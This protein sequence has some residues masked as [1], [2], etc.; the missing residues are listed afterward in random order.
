M[1]QS[2]SLNLSYTEI[3]AFLK[4]GYLLCATHRVNKHTHLRLDTH[5][6]TAIELHDQH[7]RQQIRD[8]QKV[9]NAVTNWE[10]Y[11]IGTLDVREAIRLSA[12]GLQV[13]R[14]AYV[15][16]F[17][18][19]D[20]IGNGDAGYHDMTKLKPDD[21][22]ATDWFVPL[23]EANQKI[24]DIEITDAMIAVYENYKISLNT[25]TFNGN[26][27][28]PKVSQT[29]PVELSPVDSLGYAL[30]ADAPGCKPFTKYPNATV[31]SILADNRLHRANLKTMQI[32]LDII[33]RM[34]KHMGEKNI[35][36]DELSAHMNIKK[37]A[38]LDTIHCPNDLSIRQ[39][40][41]IADA[42]DFDLATIFK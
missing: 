18:W 42:I 20:R 6:N 29:M 32:S 35:T 11:E 40:V 21:L 15:N 33:D 16:K 23:T 10:I 19:L 14:L 26:T 41:D 5:T 38:L 24:L 37:E 39:L 13:G 31:E 7:G 8:I 4:L 2:N 30:P 36:I 28:A 34:L 3:V 17:S 22:N 9:I 25:D 12:L 27:L 1:E